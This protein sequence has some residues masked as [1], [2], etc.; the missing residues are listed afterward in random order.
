VEK[1]RNVPQGLGPFGNIT[2]FMV[3][4]DHLDDP[5]ASGPSAVVPRLPAPSVSPA[6]ILVACGAQAGKT[7]MLPLVLGDPSVN[8]WSP[9]RR[10]SS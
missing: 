9:A 7:T 3:K 5:C 2:K 6:E 10:S 1:S 8:R 4:V